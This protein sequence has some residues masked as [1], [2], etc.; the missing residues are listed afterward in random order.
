MFRRNETLAAFLFEPPRQSQAG[1]D[2]VLILRGV[3]IFARLDVPR[4]VQT[5]VKPPI[6][7]GDGRSQQ[8]GFDEAERCGHVGDARAVDSRQHEGVHFVALAHQ[9]ACDMRADE[10]RCSCEKNF[11]SRE[12]YWAA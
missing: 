10:S 6:R 2:P 8:I 9:L 12:P 7:K 11:H 1:I 4:K 3:K 5:Q